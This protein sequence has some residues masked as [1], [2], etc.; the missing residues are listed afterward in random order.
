VSPDRC[1]LPKTVKWFF[2]QAAKRQA[3]EL[4]CLAHT[5]SHRS[6]VL[7]LCWFRWFRKANLN[8]RE[9]P[10]K[11]RNLNQHHSPHAHNAQNRASAKSATVA[12]IKTSGMLRGGC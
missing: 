5:S 8:S 6:E 7:N 3:H 2:G 12:A 10:T 11:L 9:N 1:P 4:D